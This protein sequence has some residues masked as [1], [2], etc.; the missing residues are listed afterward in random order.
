VRNLWFS[1]KN[2]R[3]GQ[4]GKARVKR[5]QRGEIEQR[6]ESDGEW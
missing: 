2:V 5:E 3:R 6:G 4:E 1:W